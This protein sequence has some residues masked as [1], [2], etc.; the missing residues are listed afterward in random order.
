MAG[1]IKQGPDA[2]TFPD[3]PIYLQSESG[4]TKTGFLTGDD[5]GRL[6]GGHRTHEKDLALDLLLRLDK[7]IKESRQTKGRPV[8]IWKAA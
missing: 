6:F 5:I 8:T 7:V 1:A 2:R 3:T 4:E